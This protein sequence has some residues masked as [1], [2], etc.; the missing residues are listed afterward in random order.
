MN[1]HKTLFAVLLAVVALL[2]GCGGGG[3]SPSAR[4]R[5]TA[6]IVVHW[7]TTGRLVPSST[8]YV[9]VALTDSDGKVQKHNAIRE[10]A[11]TTTV[12]FD[13]VAA[14]LCAIA[15]DA[16]AA[17]SASDATDPDP[18]TTPATA[19]GT[20][21]FRYDPS[22]QVAGQH[23]FDIALGSTLKQIEVD[24]GSGTTATLASQGMD[25]NIGISQAQTGA[26]T[27]TITPYATVSNGTTN[28]SHALLLTSTQYPNPFTVD[29][30]DT[31][32][33][34]ST[35]ANHVTKVTRQESSATSA[36]LTFTYVE[37]PTIAFRVNVTVS[38]VSSTG[39]VTVAGVPT[40]FDTSLYRLSATLVEQGTGRTYAGALT[41]VPPL[42]GS[43]KYSFTGVVPNG[44]PFSVRLSLAVKTV[45]GG[46]ADLIQGDDIPAG[47]AGAYNYTNTF[48]TSHLIEFSGSSIGDDTVTIPPGDY[49][50][51]TPTPDAVSFQRGST[52]TITGIKAAIGSNSV[53][54]DPKLFGYN[55]ATG[56]TVSGTGTSTWTLSASD[57]TTHTQPASIGLGVTFQGG[58]P[59][60]TPPGS[61][62]VTITANAASIPIGVR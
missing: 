44:K 6:S 29:S 36:F 51:V 52:T 13:G 59:D 48:G 62:P 55:P 31:L 56:L 39:S 47:S 4:S 40:T 53:T 1:R 43:R 49:A 38:P 18:S 61:I 60:H 54:L 26:L 7:P 28:P 16:Y 14:G 57:A 35:D 17:A 25:G 5:G 19:S 50:G 23:D 2:T 8:Q 30:S 9:R 22:T 45:G 15:A 27:V 34:V 32:L 37:D 58:R 46:Y 20:T 12:S 21:T 41:D 33:A 10:A 11:S 24:F 42:A 3:H